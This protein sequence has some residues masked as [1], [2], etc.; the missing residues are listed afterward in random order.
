MA[1]STSW[2][3]EK[4]SDAR[5]IF[6]A[7]LVAKSLQKND[8]TLNVQVDCQDNS[9]HFW[10]VKVCPTLGLWPMES[11]CTVSKVYQVALIRISFSAKPLCVL[12]GLLFVGPAKTSCSCCY[13]A[14][15]C[16][17]AVFNSIFKT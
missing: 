3:E 13:S 8:G 17:C 5:F 12:A 6:Y 2:A 11:S 7:N 4:S 15:Y 1:N 14:L 16:G 9:H 10:Q